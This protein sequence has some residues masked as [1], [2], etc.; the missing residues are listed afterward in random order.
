M[1][2]FHEPWFVERVREH[3]DRALRTFLPAPQNVAPLGDRAGMIG[4]ANLSA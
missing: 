1:L 3:L 4:E 2:A